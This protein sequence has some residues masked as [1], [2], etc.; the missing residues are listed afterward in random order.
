MKLYSV[1]DKEFAP[2]GKVLDGHDTAPL[3]E[4]LEKET[5]LPAAIESLASALAFL[6]CFSRSKFVK[7]AFEAQ[8]LNS[9]INF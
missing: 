1:H 5:P 7:F 3:A 2:Y 4:A 6:S 9:G 8:N